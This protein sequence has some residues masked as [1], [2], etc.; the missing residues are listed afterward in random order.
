M[1][2]L[3]TQLRQLP[4]IQKALTLFFYGLVTFG[5]IYLVGN[6]V[7]GNPLFFRVFELLWFVHMVIICNQVQTSQRELV[8]LALLAG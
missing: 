8:L 3:F 6:V 1:T 5:L 7:L 2:T 4:F